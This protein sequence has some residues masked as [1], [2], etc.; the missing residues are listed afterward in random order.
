[1]LFA[2]IFVPDFPAAAIVRNEPELR[3]QVVAVVEGTPPLLRVIAANQQARRFGVAAGM[4]KLQAA[5][6]MAAKRGDGQRGAIRRR[7]LEQ[8]AAAH[9]ALADCARPFSP[10]VEEISDAPDMVLLDLDGVERLFGSARTVAVEVARRASEL[11]LEANVAVAANLD[12][13]I[14]AARGFP[15]ATVIPEG[16]E[17]ERLA[18]LSI[19]VLL[20]N[21]SVES[22]RAREMLE[23]FDHWGIRTLRAFAALPEIA[24]SERL[25]SDGVYLQKLARGQGTRELA[26]TDTPLRFEEAIELDYPIEDMDALAFVLNRLIEQ[27]CARLAARALSTNELRLRMKLEGTSSFQSP[28]HPLTQSPDFYERT[29][30]L[31]VPMLDAK[32][33]L[34]LWQ[35][36]LRANPPGAPVAKIWLTADPVEPR[37]TQGGLFLPD[38]PE[39]ERLELTLARI[40]GVVRVRSK[41]AAQ[42]NGARVGSAEVLDTHAPDAFRVKRFVPRQMDGAPSLHKTKQARQPTTTALRRF[43]PPVRI[44]VETD[45][46]RPVR[47]HAARLPDFIAANS[48]VVWCAGPWRSSGEWWNQQWSREEWDVAVQSQADHVF[49]RLYRDARIGAWF[50]EG[51]YD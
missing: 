49:C 32:T 10:R 34:R 47:L 31:P 9:A 3:G 33:F 44:D 26:P 23:T 46:G 16:E 41:E 40:A 30:R 29:I 20:E 25:G 43:R 42:T 22:G 13:A 37:F 2:C 36:E 24:V 5:A 4:T 27:E 17:A 51:T 45:G 12:A 35:L 21:G 50:M 1:M 18:S 15:G 38:A 39:P 19:G 14:C 11:G 48:E 28:D 7:S 6:R 8:E